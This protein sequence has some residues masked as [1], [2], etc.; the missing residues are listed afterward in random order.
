MISMDSSSSTYIL[1]LITRPDLLGYEDKTDLNDAESRKRQRRTFGAGFSLSV[2]WA[3]INLWIKFMNSWKGAGRS[4]KG[5]PITLWE[6]KGAMNKSLRIANT[7][8]AQE[9]GP[10]PSNIAGSWLDHWL[11]VVNKGAIALTITSEGR[12]AFKVFWIEALIVVTVAKDGL[13]A[14]DIENSNVNPKIMLEDFD[15]V[16]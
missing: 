3:S 10:D 7:R 12:S 13:R 5:V 1:D 9:G 2:F 14:K 15:K 6:N 8:L 4:T 11:T 16:F